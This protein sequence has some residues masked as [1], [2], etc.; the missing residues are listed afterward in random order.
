M[1]ATTLDAAINRQAKD[2]DARYTIEG[3]PTFVINFK[4]ADLPGIGWP[5]IQAALDAALRR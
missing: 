5:D 4:K 2:A 1:N 3:T